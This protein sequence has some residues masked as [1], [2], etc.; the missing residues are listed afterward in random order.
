MLG[1]IILYMPLFPQAQAYAKE[2]YHMSECEEQDLALAIEGKNLIFTSFPKRTQFQYVIV[3]LINT[4]S[5]KVYSKSYSTS[6]EVNISLSDLDTGNYFIEVYYSKEQYATYISYMFS[7]KSVQIKVTNDGASFVYPLAYDLNKNIMSSRSTSVVTREQ[8]LA[9]TSDI[10]S[11]NETIVSL[12]K[13]ITEGITDDYGKTKAI[14]DYICNNIWYNYDALHGKEDYGDNSALGTLTNKK[15]VCQGISNLMAAMLRAVDVPTKVVSGFALGVNGGNEWTEELIK[16]EKSNHAWN[17]VYI[18]ERWV[19]IDATWDTSNAYENGEYSTGTGLSGYRYYDLTVE[20]LSLDHL[21]IDQ[22]VYEKSHTTSEIVKYGLREPTE[23]IKIKKAESVY[24][25]IGYYEAYAT[26]DLL[27]NTYVKF[28]SSNSKIAKVD[29]YGNITGVSYG[30]CTITTTVTIFEQPVTFTT[31]VTVDATE[32]FKEVASTATAYIGYKKSV[33]SKP[34]QDIKDYTISYSTSN[35]KIAT[36]SSSGKV[37]GVKEGTVTI[38]TKIKAFDQTITYKTKVTVKKPYV[39][40]TASTT[41]LK[42]GEKYTFKAKGYGA[43]GDVTFKVS[44]SSIAS[45]SKTSGKLTA[46]K[47]GTVTV[48][49]TIDGVKKTVKVKVS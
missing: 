38:T 34:L 28:K 32:C 15:A 7:K 21:I 20:A 10:Q 18:D 9:A 41:K 47:K 44:D 30:V 14:H 17:E 8:A 27:Q 2:T 6:K 35:K 13:Q 40:F 36:V 31:K 49:A 16:N 39:K 42:V 24:I 23:D 5:E 1:I 33:A 46:K 22:K 37:S 19:I 29:K 48:T 4:N 3:Q 45:I 25:G 12:A 43:T 26:Q 11:D